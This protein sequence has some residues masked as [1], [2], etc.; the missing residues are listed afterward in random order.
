M[1]LLSLIIKQMTQRKLRSSLTIVGIFIGISA[2][3]SL[4]LLA[5]AL[6]RGVGAQL[7]S[8]GADVILIAPL[9]AVGGGPPS[10]IGSFTTTETEIV[11]SIPQVLS[12]SE[13]LNERVD[14]RLGR[15]EKRKRVQGVTLGSGRDIQTFEEFIRVDV[16]AG[17]HLQQGDTRSLVVGDRFARE[18]FEKELFVGS[19]VRINEQR[20][21]IIGIF[22]RQ[23]T[24]DVDNAVYTSIEDMRNIVGD[25]R[26]LTA[27]SARIAPGVDLEIMEE[28]IKTRLE[29][30]RG[31]EDVAVTT[32]AQIREQ[33]GS[34]LLAINI[35]VISVALIS[36]FVGALGVTNSLYTSVL[37]RTREI[38]TM[39]AI[40]A[41]NSQILKIFVLESAFFGLVG[42]LIGIALG[43][44]LAGSFM[45]ILNT[46]GFIRLTLDIELELLIGALIFSVGLGIVAG[47]LPA[48]RASLQKPVDA[49]RYE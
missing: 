25:N 49:L 3:V 46:F 2:L 9:T 18:F 37:Q 21:T 13:L 40:G 33:I 34:F 38:G 19:S 23:G 45:A 12:V 43:V 36:L 11:R 41:K 39:K 22:E 31:V 20:F 26:A 4:I 8:F 42:G 6:E 44:L 5:G 24:Q 14:M 27:L 29:R 17:R 32:A 7:D 35:V 10:G 47:F 28:R 1:V 30:A 16:R 15:E 48:Y